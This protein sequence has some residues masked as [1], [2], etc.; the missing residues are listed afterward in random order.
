LASGATRG[1][2]EGLLVVDLTRVLAGPYCTMLLADLGARVV[3]VERPGTGDDARAFGPLRDGRSAYFDSLNRGKESIALDLRDEGDRGI[4]EALLERA[5][6]LVENFRP[7]ALGR[8]GYG[9]EAL[10]ARYPRLICAATSGFGQ[11]GPLADR[12]AYDMVVQAM[13]GIMSLTG[14][15][16]SPPTRVGTSIGDIV[17]GLFTAVG[18]GSGLHHRSRTGE[19]LYVDVA[20]LD[21][22]VAI[23]ENAIARHAATGEVPG[24]LGSRHP[25]IAPFAAFAAGDGHLV[26]AAGND[27]LFAELCTLLGRRELANDPRFLSNDDRVKNAN[28]LAKKIES[29]LAELP[30]SEWLARLEEAGIPCAPIQDVGQVVAHP[31]VLARRMVV[32]AAGAPMAGNPIKLSGY[33]DPSERRPAPELDA[34]RARILAGLGLDLS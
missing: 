31:Q 21:S 17:A 25:S 18:V 7:G 15:E 2:F 27:A 19:G 13:G 1:P 34:D 12:P 10:H 16:G 5:D 14:H 9:W 24:P 4:F 26:I 23:L 32:T 33:P 6:V 3:K 29:A 20:M 8:L 11:T 30:V 28:V 22:Q